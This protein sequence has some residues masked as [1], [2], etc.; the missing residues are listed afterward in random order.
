MKPDNEGMLKKIQE[1]I[2]SDQG[3]IYFEKE[4]KKSEIKKGRYLRFEEWLKQNDFDQLMYKLIHEHGPEY[5][6]KC[7][8]NGFEVY[9]NNKLAFI[10]DYVVD[11]LQP[12]KVPQLNCNFTNQIWFF[13]GYYFQMIH[14]Q[15][16]ITRIYNKEDM[17]LILE[18]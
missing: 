2:E 15:G 5:R 11:N 10:I 17:R 3:K 14:G 4:N 7:Y 9:P 6:E 12:V 16:I 8:H 1:W 13:N 18:V